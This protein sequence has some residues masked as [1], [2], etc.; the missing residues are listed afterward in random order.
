MLLHVAPQGSL[1]STRS[2]LLLHV[3]S[4]SFSAFGKQPTGL[5]P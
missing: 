4:F 2:D 1:A 5:H 3:S